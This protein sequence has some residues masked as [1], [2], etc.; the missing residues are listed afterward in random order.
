MQQTFPILH[1]LPLS[2]PFTFSFPSLIPSVLPFALCVSL[3]YFFLL[4]FSSCP[5]P[6]FCHLKSCEV[7]LSDLTLVMILQS[8]CQDHNQVNSHL[9]F[10]L[11]F[12]LKIYLLSLFYFLLGIFFIYIWN[13]IRKFPIHSPLPCSPTHPLLLLGPGILLSYKVYDSRIPLIL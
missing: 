10:T 11:Y 6:N 2:F 7:Q 1:F 8:L 4:L 5:N 13:A 12:K 3:S 9:A